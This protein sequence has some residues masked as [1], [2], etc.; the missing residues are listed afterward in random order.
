M[1]IALGVGWVWRGAGVVRAGCG[2]GLRGREL[3]EKL[4]AM[5]SLVLKFE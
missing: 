5:F 4:Y 2:S 3:K 1:G